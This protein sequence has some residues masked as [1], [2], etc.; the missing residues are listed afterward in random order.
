MQQANVS[1]FKIMISEPCEEVKGLLNTDRPDA[2]PNHRYLR[3]IN[4]PVY[5]YTSHGSEHIKS[6]VLMI[7]LL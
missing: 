1:H 6:H 5:H 3:P 4:L 7:D 2:S